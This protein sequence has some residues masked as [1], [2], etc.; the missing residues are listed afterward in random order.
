[1]KSVYLVLA[2]NN[3]PGS[4]AVAT[5]IDSSGSAP[6]RPG[7]TALITRDGLI[8][9]T[10]GGGIVEKRVLE[11]ASGFIGRN[12]SGIFRY[13]LGNPVP[14]SDDAICGG[15]VTVLIDSTMSGDTGFLQNLREIQK[16]KIPFAVVTSAVRVEGDEYKLSRG[17]A[18]EDFSSGHERLFTGEVNRKIQEMLDRTERENIFVFRSG[19]KEK[20]SLVIVESVPR[21]PQL[22]IAGAGHI[23]RAVCMLGSF[24]GFEVTVIDDRPEFTGKTMLPMADNIITANIGEAIAKAEKDK[25]TYIVIVTRGHSNDAEALKNCI[26]SDAAYVGMIGSRTKTELMRRDFISRGWATQEQ[27]EKIHTPIGIKISSETVEEIAL[28][29]AAELVMVKNSSGK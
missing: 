15:D 29:I 7:N 13:K 26:G 24:L 18:C 20:E 16:K 10:V 5:V 28:S 4:F 3:L 6:G 12:R 19:E 22:I 9:G 21:P 17:I 1:M 8:H 11:T 2:G 23:G 27:W 14:K 25:N